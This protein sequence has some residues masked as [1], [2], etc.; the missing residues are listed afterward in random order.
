MGR[1]SFDIE[2]ELNELLN[3]DIFSAI[4]RSLNLF[5]N[6]IK[7]S[8][9]NIILVGSGNLGRKVNFALKKN[10]IQIRAFID[11]NPNRWDQTIDN[12]KILDPKYAIEMYG[13][14]CLFIVCIWSPKNSFIK[15][16]SKLKQIGCKNVIHFSTIIWR[17]PD[18]ILPHYQFETPYYYLLNSD[19]IKYTFKMLSDNESKIQYLKHIKYRLYGKLDELPPPNFNDEYFPEDI[20]KLDEKTNFVDCGAFDGDT[21]KSFL[22]IN[23]NSFNKY[24]AIEPDKLNYSKLIDYINKLPKN[25]QKKVYP[26]N[27][28]VGRTTGKMSF[29]NA[30]GISSSISNIGNTEVVVYSLDEKLY[31]EHPYF[32]KLDIEGFEKQALLGSTKIIKNLSPILA[33]CIYHLPS[34]LWEIPIL[35][36][37]INPNY[38]FYIRT[39]DEDGLQIVLYCIPK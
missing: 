33:V 15:I 37:K 5:K 27:A 6:E 24:F 25:I 23:E 22:K 32:I 18:D 12:V 29:N 16:R 1:E 2:T 9:G 17:F 39:H 11:N 19:R 31:K 38:R 30:G 13:E 34:D 8:N 26:I 36:E 10:G 7:K 4:R 20:V 3:E 14:R 28:A 35:L 21:L